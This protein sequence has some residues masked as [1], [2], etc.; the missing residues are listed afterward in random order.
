[1]KYTR[2]PGTKKF[3]AIQKTFTLFGETAHAHKISNNIKWYDM[4]SEGG[5]KDM[6]EKH[7]EY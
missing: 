5:R 3:L 7:T 6:I 1:M 4:V 2:Y